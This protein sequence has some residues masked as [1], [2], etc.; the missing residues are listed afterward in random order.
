MLGTGPSS[1][2]LLGVGGLD[3]DFGDS[4]ASADEDFR[5]FAVPEEG[6]CGEPEGET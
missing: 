6:L 2:P 1:C 5:T 3:L 4:T